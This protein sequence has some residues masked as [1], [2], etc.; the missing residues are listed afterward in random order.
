MK[1]GVSKIDFTPEVMGIA[2]LGY[3]VTHHV[4]EGIKTRVHARAFYIEEEEGK[5]VCIVVCEIGLMFNSLRH[6]VCRELKRLAPQIPLSDENLLLIAQH[7]HSAPGGYSYHPLYNIAT[8][9][10]QLEVLET[11]TNGIVQAII[12]A[13]NK[14]EEGKLKYTEDLVPSDKKVSFNRSINAYNLNPEVVEKVKFE[15]RHLAVD[16]TMRMLQFNTNDEKEIGSINWFAVHTTTIPVSEHNVHFDNKGYAAQFLE[17]SKDN[18]YVG[19]FAHGYSGDVTG[20]FVKD[21]KRKNFRTHKGPH[22]SNDENAQFNGNIQYEEAARI[23]SSMTDVETLGNEVDSYIFWVDMSDIHIDPSYVNGEI[24]AYTSPS[25]VGVDMLIGAQSD[26]MGLP[27]FLIPMA[28]S[29][30]RSIRM[31][32][33]RI[34]STIQ[35]QE[36]KDRLTRKYETQG[37]KYIAIETGLN[38]MYGTSDIKNFVVPGFVD[39]SIRNLK[40]FHKKG[41]FGKI[42]MSAQKL[43]FQIFRIGELMIV[44]YPFE[45]TTITGKRVK[46][47]IESKVDTSKIKHILVSPYSNSYSGY[48][49]TTEEY[50]L[51]AYEGGHNVFGQWSIGAIYQITNQI[52]NEFAKPKAERKPSMDVLSEYDD[53]DLELLIYNA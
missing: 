12:Q 51:Q 2:M 41:T 18:D 13:F 7:T 30:S 34:L 9:G 28:R 36:I 8:P 4:I 33:K 23:L 40:Y 37:G 52:L 21:S 32:E 45:F 26:G 19:A 44:S 5:A 16:K 14:K 15:D 35:S 38:R 49:T 10:L 31:Y 20:N 6:T 1:I 46:A 27:E 22:E 25:C 43:P 29:V 24:N 42:S 53:L 39:D 48:M 11:Y 3:G 47:F 17:K 50:Q